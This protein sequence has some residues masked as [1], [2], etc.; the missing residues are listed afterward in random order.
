MRIFKHA[1]LNLI[2]KPSKAVMILLIMVLV[3]SLVFTGIII[4]NSIYQSREFIR[5]SLGAVVRFEP[6]WMKAMQ[7]QID[8][9]EYARMQIDRTTALDIGS[10]S[11]VKKTYLIEY[12]Y[13]NAPGLKSGIQGNDGPILYKES[14][15]IG[16]PYPPYEDYGPGMNLSGSNNPIPI[17]FE[18]GKLILSAG[19]HIT[20][21]ELD[22]GDRVILV[23][24]EFAAVN[25]LSPG[26]TMGM[27]SWEM[28]EP[29]EYTIVGIY[30][31]AAEF[32]A[33]NVYT[34]TAVIHEVFSYYEYEME[35]YYNVYF[36]LNNPLEIEGFIADS[37]EKLPSK[38]T[39]LTANE[40]DFKQLTKPLDLMEIITR[41]LVWVV[42]GAGAMIIISVVTIFIR[43]RKFEIGLLL[44]AGEGKLR[45]ATQFIFEIALVALLAFS[46][47][48]GASQ[49]TSKYVSNW[50]VENQLTEEKA[51]SDNPD[52]YYWYDYDDGSMKGDVDINDV[53]EDF[54]ISLDFGTL[55]TLFGISMGI[56]VFAAGT[57]LVIIL[58]YKPREALQES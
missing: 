43:D 19:R 26:D 41:I 55:L 20:Q 1:I 54:D 22:R 9:E 23:S 45:I 35:E 33:D 53:A 18:T 3:F 30:Q 58:R 32:A 56:L 12:T 38:Y 48:A 50:I 57:P 10:D 21:E 2:R 5:I 8:E 39:K 46:I 49:L 29:L 34:T 52:D 4:T 6:D 37:T 28:P 36:V 47:A 7:D 24:E 40:D 16:E 17:E 11:R 15:D 51:E 13:L 27:K 25:N 44:S 31:G 14:I 42:F